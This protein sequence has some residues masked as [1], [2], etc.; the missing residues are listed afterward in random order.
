MQL[1]QATSAALN[2]GDE[3]NFELSFSQVSQP[4]SIRRSFFRLVLDSGSTVNTFKDREL[5]TNVRETKKGID[6]LTNGGPA[7]YTLTGLFED[8]IR[9]WFHPQGLANIMSMKSLTDI[10]RVTFDSSDGN[11]FVASFD[12]G[13]VWRFQEMPN[14]LYCYDLVSTNKFT[15]NE[16]RDY[17]LITTVD[18][19]E[20]KFHRREVAA[21]KLAGKLHRLLGRPSQSTYEK[22]IST[23]QIQHCPVNIEDIKRFYEIYGP[24]VATLQGK[25]TKRRSPRALTLS[26]TAL[27]PSL[28]M[29]HRHVTLGVDVFYVQ[30]I[31]FFHSISNKIQFRTTIQLVN[32]SKSSL[33]SQFLTIRKLY[34]A[35]DL[36]IQTL[37]GDGE[38]KCL[39]HDIAPTLLDTVSADDNVQVV[40][41]SIQTVKADCRTLTHGLPFKRVP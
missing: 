12:I 17:C 39:T 15:N 25:T 22:A 36:V 29:H 4:E 27:P 10:S 34:E 38:F 40:K 1:V 24:D 37:Q 20:K 11:A 41:R 33:L 3:G 9:V 6:V 5:L 2:L 19:N 31:P 30:G 8:S 32:R 26:P 35:R 28:L 7:K 13:R 21:A 16:V 14:G 23:N 18:K